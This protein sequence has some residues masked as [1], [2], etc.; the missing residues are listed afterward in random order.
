MTEY[1][2]PDASLEQTTSTSSVVSKLLFVVATIGVVVMGMLFMASHQR[3]QIE[4]TELTTSPPPKSPYVSK[5]SNSAPA[6]QMSPDQKRN[7]DIC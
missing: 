2:R 1:Q 4:E 3:K 7:G 5:V 6:Q